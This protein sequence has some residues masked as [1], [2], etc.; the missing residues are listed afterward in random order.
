MLEYVATVYF[1]PEIAVILTF[2][3]ADDMSECCCWVSTWYRLRQVDLLLQ[4]VPQQ[5]GINGIAFMS[6]MFP[7]S[8]GIEELLLIETR[9]RVQQ[10]FVKG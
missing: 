9:W 3:S 4:A 1:R 5:L 8:V 10:L 7:Q 6:D 2:V